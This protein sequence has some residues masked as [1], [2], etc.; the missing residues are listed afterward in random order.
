MT[1]VDAAILVVT[2]PFAA[3]ASAALEARRP[4]P[5]GRR[6]VAPAAM[7]GSPAPRPAAQGDS[8][9]ASGALVGARR[10]SH[11]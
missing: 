3:G 6:P 11:G 5:R 8:A 4:G 10:T 1:T 7:T 2:N 9:R